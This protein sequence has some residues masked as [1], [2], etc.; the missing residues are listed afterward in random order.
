M[1]ARGR[2]P[3]EPCAAP[4]GRA[5]L[6]RS[7]PGDEHRLVELQRAAGNTAVSE[8]LVMRHPVAGTAVH[9]HTRADLFDPPGT[10]LGEFVSSLTVQATGS[11][12]R[13]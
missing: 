5:N 9:R 4:G 6:R 1:P 7:R 13:R 11:P 3:G 8:M 10:T 2:K 12:N